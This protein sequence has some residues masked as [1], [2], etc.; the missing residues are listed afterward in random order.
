MNK[1]L[2]EGIQSNA[3]VMREDDPTTL[4]ADCV[5]NVLTR[6]HCAGDARRRTFV[7]GLGA[8]LQRP[9][10]PLFKVL[11]RVWTTQYS[12]AQYLRTVIYN[13]PP[14]GSTKERDTRQGTETADIN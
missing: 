4:H 8:R 10:V 11:V 1:M 9:L 2:F 6:Q 3:I 5:A 7:S 14:K 13:G 12:T